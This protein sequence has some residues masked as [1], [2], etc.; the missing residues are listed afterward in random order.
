MKKLLLL[1]SLLSTVLS[2]YA[3]ELKIG[4]WRGV[5]TLNDS[6]QLPFNFEVKYDL[7]IYSIDFI[8][9]EER[10]TA[11]EIAIKGD[12]VFIKMPVF[13]SEFRLKNHGDS[14]KGIWFNHNRKD[15]NMLAFKAYYG[16]K[17]RFEIKHWTGYEPLV[18]GKWEVE[19][20]PG[21]NDSYKS[22]G[23]FNQLNVVNK[24][25]LTGTFFTETGDNEKVESYKKLL[26]KN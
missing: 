3:D 11:N 20:E 4:Y 23:N 15:K 17:E 2:S 21:T 25:K 24:S 14:L 1:I 18:T 12:S 10:I 5:L 8:N 22:I 13:D 6:T 9:A 19:F 16:K 26:V 7:G